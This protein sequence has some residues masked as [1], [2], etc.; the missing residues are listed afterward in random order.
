MKTFK[1]G[2]IEVMSHDYY[3]NPSDKGQIHMNFHD[4]ETTARDP[5]LKKLKEEGWRLPTKKEAFYLHELHKIWIGGFSDKFPS[6]STP[7]SN[8]LIEP[9]NMFKN[10]NAFSKPDS[11]IFNFHLGRVELNGRTSLAMIRLVRTI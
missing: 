2:L 6:Y 3:R 7:Y 4:Y 11:Q 10:V 1:A 9:T 8:Y 5:F